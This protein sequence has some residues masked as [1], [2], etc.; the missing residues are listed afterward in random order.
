MEEFTKT[1]AIFMNNSKQTDFFKKLKI[2]VTRL[3][4]DVLNG[5]RKAA[6]SPCARKM[7]AS[8][9]KNFSANG[10]ITKKAVPFLKTCKE[11]VL[12]FSKHDPQTTAFVFVCLFCAFSIEFLDKAF[13]LFFLKHEFFDLF[14]AVAT[15]NPAGWWFIILGALWLIATIYAGYCAKPEI[16]R[17]LSQKA[18][19]VVFVLMTLTI[20]SVITIFLNILAGRYDTQAL[21]K[22]GLYGFSSLSSG[23]S[24]P[25]WGAQT[26]FAVLLASGELYPHLKKRLTQIAFAV[27]I[28]LILSGRYFIS[29]VVLGA[30]VGIMGF[31]IARWLVSETRENEKLLTFH[32]ASKEEEESS[33]TKEVKKTEDEKKE[34]KEKKD[35]EK[36]KSKK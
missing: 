1:G 18:Y 8:V 5:Y 16:F 22:D 4:N 20:S 24:F 2:Y 12:Y 13:A 29:D 3:K 35:T 23:V 19:C 25:S 21:L 15:I 28:C 33:E 17:E 10:D 32:D 14:R 6:N 30:Y 26:I 36:E 7:T 31:F 27:C 9:K 34:K 11:R